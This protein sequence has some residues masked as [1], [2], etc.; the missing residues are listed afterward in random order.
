MRRA[1]GRSTMGFL[2]RLD[3]HLDENSLLLLEYW[4]NGLVDPKRC[5]SLEIEALVTLEREFSSLSGIV[6]EY[7][8]AWRLKASRD[9]GTFYEV[10]LLAAYELLLSV[11]H[12]EMLGGE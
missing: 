10:R 6:Q 4:V 11:K 8:R 5:R 1:E 12:A 9:G 7:R 3:R 2:R